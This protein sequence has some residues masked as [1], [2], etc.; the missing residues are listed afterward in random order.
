MDFKFNLIANDSINFDFTLTL[1]SSSHLDS[2]EKDYESIPLI[3]RSDNLI[4]DNG[5][6]K[7][8]TYTDKCYLQAPNGLYKATKDIRNWLQGEKGYKVLE[9]NEELNTMLL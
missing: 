1:V 7:N 9:Y 4:I 6:F 2:F 8:K 3:G 5:T